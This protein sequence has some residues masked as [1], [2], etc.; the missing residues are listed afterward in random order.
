MC[1]N[2]IASSNFVITSLR[3]LSGSAFGF[4][5][6]INRCFVLSRSAI[7]A[8]AGYAALRVRFFLLPWLPCNNLHACGGYRNE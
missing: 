1:S 4:S 5:L 6:K 7:R 2:S 3:E 8:L